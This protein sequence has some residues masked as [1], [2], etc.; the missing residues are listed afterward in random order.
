MRRLSLF[1]GLGLLGLSPAF[2][3]GTPESGT[4]AGEK[5][6]ALIVYG[7]DPCPASGGDTITVCA[8]KDEGERYRIPKDLRE[9]A[10]SH[11]EA[12]TSR[13]KAYET[14]GNF[15]TNSCSPVGG[16]GWTGC[17]QKLIDNWVDE[18]RQGTP[19]GKQ[20]SRL[21]DEERAKRASTVDADAL[22]TQARVEEAE[23]AYDRRQ[24]AQDDPEDVPATTPTP[25][26]MPAPVPPKQ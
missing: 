6:N 13:V 9:E 1:L 8:R 12:W 24:R 2:A 11:S 17:Q 18:K 20:M 16:G 7:N 10:S 25:S 3:Q 26:T 23:Q 19:E 21:I 4:G 5:I 15:G 14:V 22:A